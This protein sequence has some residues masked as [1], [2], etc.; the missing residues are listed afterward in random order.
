MNAWKAAD[1]APLGFHEARHTYAS[2]AIGAGLNAKTL[3]TY[4]GHANIAIT[5]ELYGHLMPGSEVEARRLLDDYLDRP[6]S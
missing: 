4:M 2:I 6:E 5:F 3:S 1:L